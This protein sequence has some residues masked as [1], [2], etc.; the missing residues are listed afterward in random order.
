MEILNNK[1]RKGA[2][3]AT[4]KG[5]FHLTKEISKDNNNWNLAF[6]QYMNTHIFSDQMEIAEDFAKYGV[7]KITM[8]NFL[9]KMLET[10][11]HDR[12]L[13]PNNY[14]RFKVQFR[15]EAG[16]VVNVGI[17]NFGKEKVGA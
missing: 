1:T 17:V 12:M 5:T 8:V 9:N 14:N 10:G 16:R 4:I 6:D 11:N 7:E 13:T 3:M 2:K 15:T